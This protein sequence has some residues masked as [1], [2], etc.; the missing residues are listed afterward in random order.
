MAR[1]RRFAQDLLAQVVS[2]PVRTKVVA[3]G[4]GGLVLVGSVLIT[5]MLLLPSR[6]VRVP[7]LVGLTS[8]QAGR[9]LGDLGLTLRV[10]DKRFSPSIPKDTVASQDPTAGIIVA[11]GSDVVVDLSA[12]S[13]SFAL[14]DVIGQTLDA[15]RTLLRD[16]GLSVVFVTA[17]SESASGTIVGSSPV[18]G[19]PVSTGDTV[20]LTVAAPS[21]GATAADMTGLVFVLDPTPPSQGDASDV[22]IDVAARVSGLLTAA[23]ARVRVTRSSVS[24]SPTVTPASRLGVALE[25]SATAFI[26][27]S[28][29]PSSLEGMLLLTIPSSE[30]SPEARE[31]SGPLADAMLASL[32]ADFS[33]ITTLP[34]SGDTVL[35]GAGLPG[36]RVR[37]GSFASASDTKSFAD[38]RWLELVARDIYRVLAQ[39]YGR[40]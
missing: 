16:R 38:E 23:G 19:D 9:R 7:D 22:S 40:R 39:L 33:S 11:A 17:S 13:E 6:S 31:L 27:L 2:L 26:G 1:A 12:G 24:T 29:A 25:A 36:V 37:L 15:G 20:R 21:G 30:G 5:V 8:A 28:V 3:L 18:A 32:A 14:P 34:A 35:S 4:A 10:R